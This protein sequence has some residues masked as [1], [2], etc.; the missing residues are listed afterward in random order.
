[1]RTLVTE[2]IE[3]SIQR[4]GKEKETIEKI[5]TKQKDTRK[6]LKTAESL[7]GSGEHKS[8]WMMTIET[9]I[10]YLVE[11]FADHKEEIKNA[12]SLS[13][14]QF[15]DLIIQFKTVK[16]SFAE[17]DVKVKEN[18]ETISALD[19]KLDSNY[20]TLTEYLDASK[21]DLKETYDN[22]MAAT[23]RSQK[24]AE[25]ASTRVSDI[26]SRINDLS[27]YQ[28]KLSSAQ[29]EFAI[30]IQKIQQEKCSVEQLLTETHKHSSRIEEAYTVNRRLEDQ[31]IELIR[32]IDIYLPDEVQISVSDNLYTFLDDVQ[33]IKW[34]QFEEER[35]KD[36]R[37]KATDFDNHSNL[38]GIMRK[39]VEN[40]KR[41]DT[42]TEE[43]RYGLLK[44]RHQTIEEQK[45]K[46]EEIKQPKEIFKRSQPKNEEPSKEDMK[47]VK[48]FFLDD[49]TWRK[50]IS[51]EIK[52]MRE[53]IS[54]EQLK[55]ETSSKEI[56]NIKIEMKAKFD[57]MKIDIEVM[58]NEYVDLDKRIK[59]ADLIV[60][61]GNAELRNKVNSV[62][63]QLK[64]LGK[65][66]PNL[67]EFDLMACSA[68]LYSNEDE[69]INSKEISPKNKETRES[70]INLPSISS[71]RSSYLEV[72]GLK[73]SSQLPKLDITK[74][75]AGY[76]SSAQCK[77]ENTI[78]S[79]KSLIDKMENLIRPIWFSIF[80]QIPEM[81]AKKHFKKGNKSK[82]RQN[83]SFS[84]S[85]D[86]D[87]V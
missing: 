72:E 69:G 23:M 59:S 8:G 66:I 36:I 2:L 29:R 78:Y 4:I 28:E 47:T 44:L 51:D 39:A 52:L 21:Q 48:K 83:L 68:L 55:I 30:Q 87:N 71:K 15:D 11:N 20:K 31:F 40:A 49:D 50:A 57:E 10:R 14:R 13:K 62:N 22:M 41:S 84:V 6:R 38:R 45:P 82:H 42:R 18:N 61:K 7:F 24:T 60:E 85:K 53:L 74:L 16:N 43:I 86:A 12:L 64:E 75:I 79:R 9:Q 35:R 32:Y 5:L 77:F 34:I 80:S 70:T 65:I 33:M 19:S 67:V 3:P 76:F 46:E 56:V 54:H 73:P 27:T 26:H 37:K 25:S 58:Q 17:L 1:M 81:I 63:E